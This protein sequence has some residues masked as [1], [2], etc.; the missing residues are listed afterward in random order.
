MRSHHTHTNF[1]Q[2]RVNTTQPV[3]PKKQWP[4]QSTE[5]WGLHR[6]YDD[7]H[8]WAT[9]YTF[10][11]YNDNDFDADPHDADENLVMMLWRLKL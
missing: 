5:T 10:D 4:G 8:S 9:I 2:K 6:Q 3:Q 1:L 11:G 7:Q